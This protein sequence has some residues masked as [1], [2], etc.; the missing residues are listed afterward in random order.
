MTRS[1]R[2]ARALIADLDESPR[3]DFWAAVLRT[4]DD[5]TL[6]IAADGIEDRSD[7][8]ITVRVLRALEHHLGSSI[9]YYKSHLPEV[10]VEKFLTKTLQSKSSVA[11]TEVERN[12][13][14]LGR[15]L[16]ANVP[17]IVHVAIQSDLRPIGELRPGQLFLNLAS[18]SVWTV[19]GP[20][21]DGRVNVSSGPH[22]GWIE[23]SELVLPIPEMI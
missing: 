8:P 9:D 11:Q 16:S 23:P 13:D 1:A 17:R 5:Y 15:W 18:T 6:S 2:I 7:D 21:S 22:H 4:F 19:V 14:H 12:L 10:D 20:R 3:L